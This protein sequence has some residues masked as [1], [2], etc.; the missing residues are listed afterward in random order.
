MPAF[1]I[2]DSHLHLW[3]PNHLRYPWLD[4]ISVLNKPFLLKDYDK[5]TETVSVK[6]MVFV[7]CECIF[8]QC[9][10]EAAWITH[11]AKDDTRIQ[12]IIPLAP[13]E[14]KSVI[15]VLERYAKNPLIKGIRRI[16]Q[17]EPDPDFCLQPNF[18]SG[19]QLLSKFNYTFDIC[20]RYT[21][22]PQVISL[23]SKCPDVQFVLDHIGKPDIKGGLIEPWKS[24][25]TELSRFSN[26]FCKISGLV[27]EADHLEWSLSDIKPYIDHVLECF[28]ID[29]VMFGGDWPVVVQAATFRQW[30]DSLDDIL[31]ELNQNELHRLYY[32]NAARYY[33][34]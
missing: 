7:Q 29:R 1:P 15:E 21:Q 17:F 14:E 32:E 28:G 22:L 20:I 18:V 13:L 4:D 6:K 30:I 34:L 23:V 5:A 26:V 11:L 25:V 33:K 19:V 3:D 10:D 16:I 2:I 12:G 27:T 8:S 9:E 24:Q 31:S